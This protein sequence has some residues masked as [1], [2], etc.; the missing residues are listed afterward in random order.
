MFHFIMPSFNWNIEKWKWNNEYR[1]YV[2]NLGHF[3]N[4]FKQDIP[5]KI[6][7]RGYVLIKTSQGYK[8]AHRLVLLTWRPIPDAESLTVDHLNHNKRDNSLTN[9]EWVTKEENGRRAANDYLSFEG[10]ESNISHKIYSKDYQITFDNVDEAVEWLAKQPVHVNN[11]NFVFNAQTRER[12]KIKIIEAA[13]VKKRY[14]A[15]VWSFV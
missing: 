3:K 7:T 12:M 15:T 1:V 11:T 9:L 4:E 8:F 14:S 13:K 10:E 6:N 5:V 2:S